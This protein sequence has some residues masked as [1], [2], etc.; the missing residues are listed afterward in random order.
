[1]PLEN[2]MSEPQKMGSKFG[3]I[4]IAMGLVTCMYIMM[5]FFGYWHF[6]YLELLDPPQEIEGSVTLNLPQDEW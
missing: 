3:A 6:S 4:N 1:M 2:Q 5:G